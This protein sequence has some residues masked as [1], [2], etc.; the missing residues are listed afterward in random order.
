VPK[1]LSVELCGIRVVEM[2]LDKLPKTISNLCP[3]G[4]V[5]SVY[6]K[7]CYTND[8]KP[9]LTSVRGVMWDPYGKTIIII[10]NIKDC[11]L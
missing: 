5:G 1:P 9:Y 3:G 11:T 6:S 2:L 10:I 4:Y 7:Y 8:L